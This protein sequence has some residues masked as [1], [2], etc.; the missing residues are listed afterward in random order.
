MRERARERER[1]MNQLK[2][3]KNYDLLS[4]LAFYVAN[5]KILTLHY[6]F[7]IKFFSILNVLIKLS[8]IR[9]FEKKRAIH[10]N[11]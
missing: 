10:V 2:N 6:G 5:V 9:S 11:I 1:E 8:K 3:I 7:W 4:H